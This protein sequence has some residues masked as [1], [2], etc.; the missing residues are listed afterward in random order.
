M[1]PVDAARSLA[2]VSGE[3]CFPRNGLI[4]GVARNDALIFALVSGVTS[5]PRRAARNFASV[6]GDFGLPVA[7]MPIFA[8]ASADGTR[9]LLA[10]PC[11]ARDSA[12]RTLPMR[13]VL[14]AAHHSGD[15]FALARRIFSRA[16]A[17][18]GL[19]IRAALR[20]AL[21]SIVGV[22][23]LGLPAMG[24]VLKPV[25]CIADSSLL[26]HDCSRS[27]KSSLFGHNFEDAEYERRL[28]EFRPSG[29]QPFGVMSAK[30]EE[31]F[32]VTPTFL[33]MLR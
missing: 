17:D 14:R 23:P 31:P 25:R 2:I 22:S 11:L 1:T 18:F 19:P 3:W 5:W 8:R 7:A 16:S 28:A 4:R 24:H 29:L 10:A 9:P 13:A 32:V 12:E 26:I 27:N 30:C 6:S 21:V 33:H 15:R 20:R